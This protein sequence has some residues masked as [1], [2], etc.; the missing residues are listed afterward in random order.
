MFYPW[1]NKFSKNNFESEHISDVAK[2]ITCH[3]E[4]LRYTD[5]PYSSDE[6]LV[7]LKSSIPHATLTLLK[8]SSHTIHKRSPEDII[9]LL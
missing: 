7:L 6:Q 4:V 9:K 3:V 1:V 8:G 5:D 2:K